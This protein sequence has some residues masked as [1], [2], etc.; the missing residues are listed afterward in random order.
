[1]LLSSPWIASTVL[2]GESADGIEFGPLSYKGRSQTITNWFH[3]FLRTLKKPSYKNNEKKSMTTQGLPPP[4]TSGKK[5]KDAS[6]ISEI[7]E[8]ELQQRLRHRPNQLLS[9]AQQL[10]T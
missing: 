1:M 3:H 8:K 10:Y 9:D 2:Y 7:L 4:L 5:C 6:M